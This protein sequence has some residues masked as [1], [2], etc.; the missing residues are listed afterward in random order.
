MSCCFLQ[1]YYGDC[2]KSTAYVPKGSINAMRCHYSRNLVA[3]HCRGQDYFS[4]YIWL[5]CMHVE[6]KQ[7]IYIDENY[8][9]KIE[10]IWYIIG[11]HLSVRQTK[12]KKKMD[13]K[14][15]SKSRM[16]QCFRYQ[17]IK[18]DLCTLEFR[19]CSKREMHVSLI[20][21]AHIWLTFRC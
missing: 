15:R 17:F 9:R 7:R 3:G 6:R 13:L 1:F 16:W 20:S 12:K 18:M 8:W 2:M 19:V 5:W 21:V 14:E 11:T 10:C 4:S